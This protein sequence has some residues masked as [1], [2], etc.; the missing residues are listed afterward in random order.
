MSPEPDLNINDMDYTRDNILR[1]AQT[2]LN[3]R[4]ASKDNLQDV[5]NDVYVRLEDSDLF[6]YVGKSAR[7]STTSTQLAISRQYTLIEEHAAR[8]RPVELGRKV[9]KM[10]L[11]IAPVDSELKVVNGEIDLEKMERDGDVD[12][13]SPFEVGFNCE[14][15]TN[16]GEGFSVKRKTSN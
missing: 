12:S 8:L 9:G 13:V 7:C 15:V 4:T 1:Q 6:W 11:W 10:E 5:C 16:K 3:I 14:Y 2:Y